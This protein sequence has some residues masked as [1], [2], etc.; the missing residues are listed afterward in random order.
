MRGKQVVV[1]DDDV[2]A[3]RLTAIILERGGFSVVQAEGPFEALA[4]LDTVTPDLFILDNMMPGMSGIELCRELRARTQTAQIPVFM[5]SS[6]SD[7]AAIQE[8][9]VAGANGYW[10]KA[11]GLLDLNKNIRSYFR[12]AQ[13]D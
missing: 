8:A 13:S 11:T 4:M 2:S 1:V 6:R 3:L 9:L 12:E 7:E 5:L 10:S